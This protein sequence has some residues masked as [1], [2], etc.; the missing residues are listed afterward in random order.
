MN[1]ILRRK[2]LSAAFLFVLILALL[3]NPLPARAALGISDVQP[4]TVSLNTSVT[5]SITGSDFVEGA[6]A[7]LSNYGALDTVFVS[8]TNLTAMLPAG[9]A[10]GSYTLTVVNPDASS[11]S[12]PNAVSVE[13]PTPTT[14]PSSEDT[15]PTPYIRPLVVVDT[16]NF[17]AETLTPGQDFDLVVKLHNIGGLEALNLI[18]TFT[19]GEVVRRRAAACWPRFR[20]YQETRKTAAADDATSGLY[21][22]TIAAVVMRLSYTDQNGTAYS[23]TFELSLP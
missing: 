19:P 16:Y 23:E 20:S 3:A 13:Q 1:T 11:V 15:T 4:R 7:S 5:L 10:P 17:G 22:K 8:A 2:P 9:I 21:G 18:A 14:G 12:F 6:V